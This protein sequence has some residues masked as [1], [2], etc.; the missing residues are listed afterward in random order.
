M[1]QRRKTRIIKI[2]NIKIGGANPIAIQSMAK[3]ATSNLRAVL[4]Q[5]RELEDAACP[6]IRLAVKDKSDAEAIGKIRKSTKVAL[7]A[8][9]HFDYRLALRAIKNGIDKIRLN[10]GNI[11]KKDEVK[12]VVKACKDR[13][14]PIRLGLN[15]GSL[16]KIKAVTKTNNPDVVQRLTQSALDYIKILED[17]HFFNIV[18]SVKSSDVLETIQAYK[19]LAGLCD[20]PFHLGVTAAGPTMQG[21]VKSSLGL[22]VL[23]FNGIG[24]TIR[25]SL[26]AEP[27][28]E[29]YAA[30]LILQNLGLDTVKLDI[31]SC[32][33]CGRCEVDLIKIVR[34]FERRL[35]IL[36][37]KLPAKK[38]GPIK[39]ALMGCVVNGPGEAKEAD[40][41]IAFG[42][43]DGLFFKKGI[44]RFKVSQAF[45]VDT[46]LKE[47]NLI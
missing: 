18:V 2:G 42:R 25:V 46:I 34:D 15:S 41:G 27:S 7:V 12:E 17:S 35:A 1:I 29:A 45:A 20:Y 43:K 30:R 3:V 16:P 8:D 28:E 23:L 22:G 31:I 14:I 9:I 24:D 19:R 39:I 26:T 4:K 10:P 40:L 36:N 38:T 6:I 47:L 5:I 21:L 44:P 11:Y 32:P 37:S 33:T 13:N